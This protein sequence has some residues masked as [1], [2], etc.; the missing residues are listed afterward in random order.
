MFAHQMA[1]EN[2]RV[3]KLGATV[4]TRVRHLV[5]VYARVTLQVA[6]IAETRVALAAD[7]L[8]RSRMNR[9]VLF[10]TLHA[11]ERTT[12]V[13]ARVLLR[14]LARHQVE[15]QAVGLREL[16]VAARTREVLLAAVNQRVLLEHVQAARGERAAGVEALEH[17]RVVVH[18]QAVSTEELKTTHM[19]VREKTHECEV[20]LVLISV[21]TGKVHN[22]TLDPRFPLCTCSRLRA[23]VN[24]LIISISTCAL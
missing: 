15:P 21:Y 8:L 9:S 3:A 2:V 17:L 5:V 22:S 16:P 19:R 13:A 12:A 24:K 18:V 4:F 7:E 1:L 11:I 6:L 23:D 20:L 14:V 10:E